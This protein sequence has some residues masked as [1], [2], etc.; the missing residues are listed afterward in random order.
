MIIDALDFAAVLAGTALA[1][2]ELGYGMGVDKAVKIHRAALADFDAAWSKMAE[3][4]ARAIALGESLI[5][6]TRSRRLNQMFAPDGYDVDT[7][8]QFNLDGKTYRATVTED[9]E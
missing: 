5:D 8:M 4:R 3:K 1:V 6:I 2:W 7:A 9:G